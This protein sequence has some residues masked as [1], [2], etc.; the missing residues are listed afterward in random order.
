MKILM[1]MIMTMAMTSAFAGECKLNSECKVE[2]DC[3]SLSKDY[4]LVG[5]KCINPNDKQSET[6][7]ADILSSTAAKGSTSDAPGSAAIK[8]SD[9]VAK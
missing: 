4:A 6:K 5:G 2:A 8:G 3:K 7:C 9:N 1:T